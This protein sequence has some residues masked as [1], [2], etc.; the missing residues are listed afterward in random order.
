MSTRKYREGEA[1]IEAAVNAVVAGGTIVYPTETCYGIGGDALDLD[2][3]DKVY[4]LKQRPREK[5]LTV[6]VGNLQMAEKYCYLSPE[7]RNLCEEFMPGPLTLVA[8]RKRNV[9]DALND[10]FVFRVPGNETAR[11]ITLRAR[12]PVIA[13]SANVSGQP[14]SYTVESI[15]EDIL[16]GVDVVVD[17]GELEEQPSSTI[18]EVTDHHAKILREGPISGYSIHQ[19]LNE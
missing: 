7:E 12:T 17:G 5:K 2:V 8:N 10:R 18:V 9:P 3:I 11:Q 13:T 19:A 1:G 14:S 6:I 16:Y 4:A 15:D